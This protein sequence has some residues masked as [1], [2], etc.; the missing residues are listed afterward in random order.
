MIRPITTTRKLLLVLALLGVF[1]FALVTGAML[2]GKFCE[3]IGPTGFLSDEEI[4]ENMQRAEM[5]NVEAMYK[6]ERYYGYWKNDPEN[7]M[8]WTKRLAE[9]GDA[10]RQSHY[11]YE[12]YRRAEIAQNYL[13]KQNLLREALY[14]TEQANNQRHDEAT[15]ALQKQIIEALNDTVQHHNKK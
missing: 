7:K 15:I 10:R 2:C 11:A 9:K 5:G 14:W 4:K 8:V 3:E 13:T 6:L 12:L 1:I